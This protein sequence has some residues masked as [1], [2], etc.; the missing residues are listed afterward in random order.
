MTKVKRYRV[1]RKPVVF[2]GRHVRGWVAATACLSAMVL[3][4]QSAGSFVK[5][6]FSGDSDVSVDAPTLWGS[7]AAVAL[8]FLSTLRG[9]FEFRF[10]FKKLRFFVR[11]RQSRRLPTK[12]ENRTWQSDLGDDG[13]TTYKLAKSQDGKSGKNLR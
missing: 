13:K 5:G 1:R 11:G 9:R 7:T 8:A 3:T 10:R 6:I 4:A 12:G 2:T